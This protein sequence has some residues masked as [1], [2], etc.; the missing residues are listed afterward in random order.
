MRLLFLLFIIL[1]IAELMLLLK[2]GQT[3]GALQTIALVL[4]TAA[5]GV[6]FLRRQ[7][8]AT[9]KRAHERLRDG[10]LPGREIIE[11]FMI[12]IGGALLLTPG[13]ITD[14]MA[15]VL[16]LPFTRGT[17]VR[18]LLAKGGLA[19]MSAGPGGFMFTRFGGSRV[20]GVWPPQGGPGR[21]DILEGEFTREGRTDTGLR[22][23]DKDPE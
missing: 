19:A 22:S 15:L 3:I 8:A 21:K 14:L 6:F 4:L 10:E 1:P 12:S 13:F 11:G 9:I 20:S 18:Y 5:L 23:P 17:L 16:L 2:V 7:S